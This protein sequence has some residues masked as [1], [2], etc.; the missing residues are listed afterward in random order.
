MYMRSIGTRC[1]I[2]I[3]PRMFYCTM[4]ARAGHRVNSEY[5]IATSVW[6]CKYVGVWSY[7]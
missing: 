4:L 7:G 6:W 5:F 1:F 3:R 2:H